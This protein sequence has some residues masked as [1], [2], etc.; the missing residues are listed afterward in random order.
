[1]GL[2]CSVQAQQ[3]AKYET[4]NFTVYSDRTESVVNELVEELEIFRII[5]ML[6][7]GLPVE[8]STNQKLKVIMFGSNRE[9]RS[10]AQSRNIAG[11][12]TYAYGEPRMVMGPSGRGGEFAKE[13]LF[14][15]YTHFLTF[16]HSSGFTYPRWYVEGI[17]SV[18][19]ATV[20]ERDS[21][22]VGRRPASARA[23]DNF[24]SLRL[25]D[26]LQNRQRN[27]DSADFEWRFYGTSW[28]LTHYLQIHGLA[29]DRELGG[30]TRDYLARY[31][32]GQDSVEAFEEVFGP[33]DEF[34]RVIASYARQS[35]L[36]VLNW[37]KPEISLQMTKHAISDTEKGYVIGELLYSLGQED[38]ALE[39]LSSSDATLEYS[40]EAISLKAVI[41]NHDTTTTDLA[42]KL[43][44]EAVGIA[45]LS[46]RA[47]G[48]L[49]HYEV[50]SY[51]RFK[52]AGEE[53][54]ASVRLE[55][56]KEYAES[57]LAKDR[58]EFSALWYTAGI[59][60][61]NDQLEEALEML[62][63]AW[64]AH[65]ANY[66]VR[67]QITKLLLRLGDVESAKPIVRSLIGAI[68]DPQMSQRL[69]ELAAQLDNGE[70]DLSTLDEISSPIF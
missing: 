31:H 64:D 44:E 40:G 55:R 4:Q 17:A 29:N 19:G 27:N 32:E 23:V 14:H 30:K 41:L 48:N 62:V 24:G 54:N 37:T 51:R 5:A 65:P 7:L 1:M 15:E 33:L 28:L 60:I 50:D 12:F 49:A 2:S 8:E 68:H 34:D 53:T 20:I 3:W 70:V 11:F 59:L 6:Q 47:L 16:E 25:I 22:A 39:Y 13:L 56:A 46:A 45:N 43:A 21:V 52:E 35:R 63:A 36:P 42:S 26:V 9:F 38:L 57:S 67:L 66:N 10:V 58:T 18:I 69:A 61:E